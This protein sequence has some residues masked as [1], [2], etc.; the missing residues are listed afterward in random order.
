MSGLLKLTRA[1]RDLII[2]R[3]R[4][5]TTEKRRKDSED[6]DKFSEPCI[7]GKNIGGVSSSKSIL[8]IV[9]PSSGTRMNFREHFSSSYVFLPFE[10]MEDQSTIRIP[11]RPRQR[12]FA[13]HFFIFSSSSL[14][15]VQTYRKEFASSFKD[16]RGQDSW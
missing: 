7:F 6:A 1:T 4:R 3:K 8:S 13:F 16:D 5:K 12:N 14:Q 11:W 2:Q 15:Q 10:N 9:Y